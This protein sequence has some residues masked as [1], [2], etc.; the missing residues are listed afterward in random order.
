MKHLKNTLSSV[1]RAALAMVVLSAAACSAS[2]PKQANV[3]SQSVPTLTLYGSTSGQDGQYVAGA[4]PVTT[5]ANREVKTPAS[6]AGSA[7][8]TKVPPPVIT[9]GGNN[10]TDT[11]GHGVT[12]APRDDS[13]DIG[14]TNTMGAE[15][16]AIMDVSTLNDAQLA[17]IVGAI[18]QGEIQES[19]LAVNKATAAD[20]KR[21]ARDM[22]TAHR[23][24]QAKSTALLS[25]LQITPADNAVSN[26]LKS[27]TQNELSTLQTMR[28]KDFDRD[29]IDA[30]V[31]NHNK[32]LELLDRIT[33]NVKNAELKAALTNDRPK[34]EAHLRE[35]ERV[36]QSLQKGTTNAQPE[37]S[38]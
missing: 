11:W 7:A 27:D 34:V 35:A 38:R 6:S 31:R 26:Q 15:S 3:P 29:Y 17:A 8:D 28:G 23:E 16:G 2:N 30:Q 10:P 14:S 13:N 1:P 21:F 32:A 36:Q 22:S 4:S 5:E 9:S 24:M 25:R 18:N 33:P 12:G 37:D 20:V 19:Q